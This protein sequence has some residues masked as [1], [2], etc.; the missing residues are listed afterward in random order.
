[1]GKTISVD[2]DITTEVDVNL[3]DVIDALP[4]QDLETELRSRDIN[5]PDRDVAYDELYYALRDGDIDK[6]IEIANPI[7]YARIGRMV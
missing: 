1:M 4:T 5:D 6:A 3:S 7:L 2:V